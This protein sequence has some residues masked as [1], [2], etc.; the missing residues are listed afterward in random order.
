MSFNK[1]TSDTQSSPIKASYVYYFMCL[2]SFYSSSVKSSKDISLLD[3]LYF[4]H[5]LSVNSDIPSKCKTHKGA[6]L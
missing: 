4:V 6:P 1:S 2:Y 3:L 5:I